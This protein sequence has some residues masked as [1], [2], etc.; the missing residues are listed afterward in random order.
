MYIHYLIF[1]QILVNVKHLCFVMIVRILGYGD[2]KIV[3]VMITAAIY[4]YPALSI[5]ITLHGIIDVITLF[6]YYGNQEWRGINEKQVGIN[7]KWRANNEI[8]RPSTF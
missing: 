7:E 6:Y 3:I 5:I 4:I 1:F 8:K 2:Y